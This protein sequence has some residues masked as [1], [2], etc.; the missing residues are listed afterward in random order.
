LILCYSINSNHRLCDKKKGKLKVLSDP[1]V[2]TLNNKEA[3]INI[4]DQVPYTTTDSAVGS[5]GA[6]VT[7][8]K[9]TYVPSGITLKVTPTINS[10]GRIAM[11][12]NPAVSQASGGSATTPPTPTPGARIP[13]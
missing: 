13:T 12:L 10:D 5:G 11:H 8:Q 1:K 7:T 4:T 9:V 2:A 3:T 6:T